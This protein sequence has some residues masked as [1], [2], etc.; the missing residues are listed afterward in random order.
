M[1]KLLAFLMAALI[2]FS[3]PLFCVRAEE[4]PAPDASASVGPSEP[5]DPA[6]PPAVQDEPA[7]T[8][9]PAGQETEEPVPTPSPEEPSEPEP[10]EEPVPTPFPEEPSEPEPTEEPVPTP[11]PEEPFE[12]EPTEDPAEGEEGP[13]EKPHDQPR[14]SKSLKQWEKDRESISLTGDLREDILIIARSQLGYSAD[15]T[16][17]EVTEAGRKR[18]Y[19]RYGDWYGTKYCDWC[20]VFV[21]FCIHYA[22]NDSYPKESSCARH[23]INLK[24]TGYWREWNSYIPK[25]G[26]IV[27]FNFKMNENNMMPTH[28]GL[29]EEV[30]PAEDNKPGQL[31]TIEG[32]QRNPE[33]KT[34]CVRRMVRDLDAV[35]GYGTY[36]EGKTY[37]EAYT[38]RSN[39]WT[40]I[41]ENSSLF[42]EHPTREALQ[43]LG[44]LDSR[45]YQYWFPEEAA[46]EKEA[47]AEAEPEKAPEIKAK[48]KS[49]GE[50]PS[51]SPSKALQPEEKPL[52][53]PKPSRQDRLTLIPA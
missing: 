36:E 32:N 52:V 5:A 34:A 6:E 27:F 51:V 28:V 42:V 41:D 35:V 3:L 21:S 23:M 50:Q 7:P 20:D 38:V 18:Y 37:P 39:G 48:A 40:I 2:L 24:R 16:C 14:W 43:F 12:P 49:K 1:K 19:T 46:E 33:G 45:Y 25:K 44:L 22:G 4:E 8:E 31:I 26:D 13:D 53:I 10:T 9:P 29:V 17:Y 47:E 15:S 30:I 11:S